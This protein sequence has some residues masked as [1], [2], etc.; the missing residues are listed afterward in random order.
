M[1]SSLKKYVIPLTL[2]AIGVLATFFLYPLESARVE[3][4]LLGFPDDSET[5]HGLR[6]ILLAILCL[7]PAIGAFIHAKSSI[8]DRYLTNEFLKSFGICFT[9]FLAMLFLM[10]LQNHSSE[11]KK[12]Q[13][14]EVISFYLVQIPGLLMMIIPY[15]LMLTIFNSRHWNIQLSL[16]TFCRSL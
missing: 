15:S 16:G 2:T 8:M 3:E 14:H 5:A 10:E 12:A 9:A 4:H 11:M 6:P 1:I 13:A 7:L